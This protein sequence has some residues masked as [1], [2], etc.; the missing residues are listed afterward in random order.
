VVIERS[1]EI[2]WPET[3]HMIGSRSAVLDAPIERE[4]AVGGAQ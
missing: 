1:R 2:V 3:P 4:S